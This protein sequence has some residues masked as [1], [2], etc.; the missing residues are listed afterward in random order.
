VVTLGSVGDRMQA[1]VMAAA[2]AG[3]AAPPAGGRC[4]RRTAC[5][6]RAAGTDT[7]TRRLADATAVV[8]NVKAAQ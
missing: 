6:C 5:A 7:A 8:E 3:L 4:G 2:L 1:S